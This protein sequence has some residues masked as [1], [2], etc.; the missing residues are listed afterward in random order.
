LNQFESL[1]IVRVVLKALV[2]ASLISPSMPRAVHE[3]C[4]LYADTAREAARKEAKT[5]L[6][7]NMIKV[8]RE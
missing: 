8:D 5:N 6:R 1:I 7:E 4:I 2:M 3:L